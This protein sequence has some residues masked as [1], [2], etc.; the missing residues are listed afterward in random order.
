MIVE[1]LITAMIKTLT[2]F[3]AAALLWL[4]AEGKA[5]QVL[6]VL[7]GLLILAY[8]ALLVIRKEERKRVEGPN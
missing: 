1:T 8:L 4:S 5:L 6:I 2:P 3:A 7:P